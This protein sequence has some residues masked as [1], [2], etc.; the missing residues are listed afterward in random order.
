MKNYGDDEL[1]ANPFAFAAQA[2]AAPAM[3]A[4]VAAPVIQ[5][6]AS[7]AKPVLN[8]QP[9]GRDGSLGTYSQVQGPKMRPVYSGVN[10]NGDLTGFLGYE[11]D[12]SQGVVDVPKPDAILAEQARLGGK[13]IEPIYAQTTNTRGIGGASETVSYGPPIGYRYDN[14]QSQYVNFDAG[15]QYQGTADRQNLGTLIKDLAPLA[16]AALGANFLVPMLSGAGAGGA[17]LLADTVAL[18]A[19]EVATLTAEQIAA[20]NA[21]SY[22]AKAAQ[23]IP[24]LAEL[25]A[26]GTGA[27]SAGALNFSTLLANPAALDA[28]YGLLS[29][30]PLIPPPF[31]NTPPPGFE[32]PAPPPPP[33][34][35]TP[36]PGFEPPGPPPLPN[37]PPPGFEPPGPPPLPNTP[38]PGFE[39]PS[40]KLPSWATI[41]NALLAAN[42]VANVAKANETTP[43]AAPFTMTPYVPPSGKPFANLGMSPIAAPYTPTRIAGQYDPTMTPG[44][45]SPYELIMQQMQAPKNLYADFEAGTNI[46]GYD[47]QR[48]VVPPAEAAAALPNNMGGMINKSRM[49]GPDPMGPDNGFASIQDGEFVMNRKATQKYGI[50]LMNAINSGKISKGKLSGLLQA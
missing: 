16:L 46:G 2:P 5:A 39:P 19:G 37:T 11:Q 10:R 32:P 36:P 41:P 18:G 40:P 6:D 23:A 13:E 20:A 9:I 35:N 12:P 15:G 28:A 45:V 48:F 24:S 50:E 47:P 31:P 14:G 7:A 21:A 38:P 42:L 34:P 26:S 1:I 25:V 44:G 30:T 22:A 29:Q 4:P 43:T 3:A 8:S 17:G 27:G 49:V 33:L